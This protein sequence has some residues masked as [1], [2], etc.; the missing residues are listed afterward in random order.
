MTS[1]KREGRIQESFGQFLRNIR[2]DLSLNQTQFAAKLEID[3]ANLSKMENDK[4]EFDEKKLDLLSQFSGLDIKEIQ[5][6]YYGNFIAKK[7]YDSQC[8]SEVFHVAE[9]KFNYLKQKKLIQ[10]NL[11]FYVK[12][13]N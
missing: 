11:N 5:T 10:G 9:Q 4:R 7:L 6:Q 8:G 3:A 2:L 13:S 1:Q 12:P